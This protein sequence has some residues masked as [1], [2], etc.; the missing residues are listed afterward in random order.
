MQSETKQNVAKLLYHLGTDNRAKADAEL[1][2]I[3][4]TKIKNS[5]YKEYEKVK[6]TFSKEKE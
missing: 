4:Q 3:L 6:S 2:K 1:R 5:L